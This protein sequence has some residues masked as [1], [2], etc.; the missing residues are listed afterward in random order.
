MY[1]Y[2]LVSNRCTIVN[3]YLVAR[4]IPALSPRIYVTAYKSERRARISPKNVNKHQRL[5]ARRADVFV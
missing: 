5:L 3:V 4:L 2:T 1:V